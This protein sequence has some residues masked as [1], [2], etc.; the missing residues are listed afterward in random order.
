MKK[1]YVGIDR[2][3]GIAILLVLLYH[4][5][6]VYPVNLHEIA[7]CKNL[8]SLLWFLEM[9][10]FFI[11]SGFCFSYHGNYLEYFKKKASRIL[12]PHLVFGALDILPRIIKN[13]LVNKQV[14]SREAVRSFI[15]YGGSDWFLRSLFV[16]FLLFPLLHWVYQ[17]NKAGRFIAVLLVVVLYAISDFLP[18][19]MQ[20]RMSAVYLAF[21][22]TGYLLRKINY[23]LVLRPMISSGYCA[24]MGFLLVII[25]YYFHI[26]VAD[27]KWN[28][29][30][31]GI[32]GAAF[33]AT[34]AEKA[35]GALGRLLDLCG[36]YS[37]QMYLLGGYALVASRTILTSFLGIQIPVLII[38][39][40]FVMDV[41]LTI[42]ISK[43]LLDRFGIF[44]KLSGLSS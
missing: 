1:H 18:N 31:G 2:L 43:Y 9:P 6:I 11:V 24:V 35:D 40:N 7:W 37:L 16:I 20:L 19:I 28:A 21:F 36:K 39:L 41:T 22:M 27:P 33:F 14:D 26:N 5:I 15:L 25:L 3:R 17:K 42:L 4:S 30:L 44:K 10:I 8:H 32:A 34:F 38:F 29:L 13:P 23:E 12:I